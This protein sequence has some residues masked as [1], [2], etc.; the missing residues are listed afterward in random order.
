MKYIITDILVAKY[1]Y[2]DLFK[3][4]EEYEIV[5]IED[6]FGEM[7]YVAHKG[8]KISGWGLKQFELDIQFEIKETNMKEMLIEDVKKLKKGDKVFIHWAKDDYPDDVRMDDICE[9]QENDGTKI[10]APDYCWE[11]SYEGENLTGNSIDT[12]RG[13]AYFYWPE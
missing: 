3:K 6:N 8:I 12:S 4:G 1:D 10:V 2:L 13:R 5:D 7:F 9:V 11:W